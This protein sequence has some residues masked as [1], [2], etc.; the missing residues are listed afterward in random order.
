[1]AQFINPTTPDEFASC[2]SRSVVNTGTSAF[3]DFQVV[4]V[5]GSDPSIVQFDLIHMPNGIYTLIGNFKNAAP[6]YKRIV[7]AR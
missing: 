7:I 1:M 4:V 2:N 3:G 6:S 5:D